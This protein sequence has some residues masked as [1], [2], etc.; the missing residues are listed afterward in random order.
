MTTTVCLSVSATPTTLHLSCH[1]TPHGIPCR[2]VS[3]T[4]THDSNNRA[5]SLWT[6]K[7]TILEGFPS[8]AAGPPTEPLPL[9]LLLLYSI[10]AVPSVG[11]V[12]PSLINC[13]VIRVKLFNPLE[14]KC[15]LQRSSWCSQSFINIWHW[16][17][18]YS[19]ACWV[20]RDNFQPIPLSLF[21]TSLNYICIRDWATIS[22]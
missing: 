10:P 5:V 17:T 13:R 3:T 11:G 7:G 4:T 19:L 12:I 20:S 15:R 14:T 16:F 6:K 21:F 1:S 8:P 22:Q 9:C 2:N 18:K